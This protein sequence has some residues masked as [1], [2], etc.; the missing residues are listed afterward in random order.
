MLEHKAYLS[1]ISAL[2][3]ACLVFVCSLVI[4]KPPSAYAE[5]E[6][7][8]GLWGQYFNN[9]YEKVD[10]YHFALMLDP[11]YPV[12]SH[13][14]GTT[15][16][17]AV[18]DTS[19]WPDPDALNNTVLAIA[20]DMWGGRVELEQCPM[21]EATVVFKYGGISYVGSGTT[22]AV[23]VSRYNS[24]DGILVASGER[25]EIDLYGP[26][27]DLNGAWLAWAGFG[28]DTDTRRG[29]VIGHELGHILG[30]ADV[31]NTSEADEWPLIED[32]LM[33]NAWL[34]SYDGFPGALIGTSPLSEAGTPDI[35]GL[36]ILQYDPWYQESSFT[37]YWNSPG[38]Y[39]TGWRQIGASWY[40]FRQTANVPLI[41]PVGS[42]VTGSMSL[43][44]QLYLFSLSGA[45]LSGFQ[46]VDGHRY[47]FSSGGAALAGWQTISGSTYYFRPALNSPTTGPKYS[48][49]TG[50]VSNGSYTYSFSS[51]GV[52]LSSTSNTSNGSGG[53]GLPYWTAPTS[54]A[55]IDSTL[56]KTYGVRDGSAGPDFMG[57]T[58][59]NFDFKQGPEFTIVQYTGTTAAQL[60]TVTGAALALWATSVNES[61]N[62][63]YQNLY[64]NII[65]GPTA[66]QP[67]TW[68]SNYGTGQGI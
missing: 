41:G 65:N 1:K 40:Y 52:L 51:N 6:N 47:Y 43:S 5:G 19:G 32:A 15:I 58:N 12:V 45:V 60:G 54:V 10:T 28:D 33:G 44:G 66:I 39:S 68:M 31:Y 36:N 16:N 7:T 55:S 2:T 61:P 3:I 53:G 4:A 18:E 24:N 56:I 67:T 57:V 59:T 23:T 8:L 26:W 50:S 34:G 46:V 17:Y 63:Y 62:P 37:Y 35:N 29:R 25:T 30:L 64:F 48:A 9:T 22:Y 11:D 20:E 21:N 49:V 14:E 13:L 38:A 27:F 42:M